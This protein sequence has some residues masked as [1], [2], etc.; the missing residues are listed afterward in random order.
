MQ[1]PINQLILVVLQ[2]LNKIYDLVHAYVMVQFV[3]LILMVLMIIAPNIVNHL[4]D[5][6]IF[7]PFNKKKINP[8]NLHLIFFLTDV[9]YY[10]KG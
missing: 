7:L 4:Q 9:Q 6:L 5:D 8:P 2:L 10:Q 3:F 1:Y